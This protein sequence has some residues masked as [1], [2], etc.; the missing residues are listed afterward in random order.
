MSYTDLQLREYN[1]LK[2]EV[3]FYEREL[4]RKRWLYAFLWGVAVAL[5]FPFFSL[6]HALVDKEDISAWVRGYNWV[7]VPLNTLL[8]SLL[9]YFV[10]VQKTYHRLINKRRAQ[11]HLLLEHPDLEKAVS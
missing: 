2:A 6:L 1:K 7:K 3:L 11:H 9:I 8:A 10:V 4:R 5:L